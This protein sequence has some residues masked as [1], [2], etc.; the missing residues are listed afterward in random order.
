M[1]T[2]SRVTWLSLSLLGAATLHGISTKSGFYDLVESYKKKSVL[3][4]GTLYNGKI[5]TV[6]PI[7]DFVGVLIQF[8]WPCV[9][10]NDP[11]LSLLS[12][13]FGGQATSFVAIS[14][15]D[16]LRAGNKG[17]LVS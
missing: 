15:L 10:G 9:D 1:P 5:T 17:K 16:A 12:F 8:F 2:I 11:G 6:A 3:G 13:L 4:D 14:L 7:D